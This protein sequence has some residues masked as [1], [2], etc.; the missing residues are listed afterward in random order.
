MKSNLSFGT[1]QLTR[2]SKVR[3]QDVQEGT[4]K[5]SKDWGTW[6]PKSSSD[7]RLNPIG[8]RKGWMLIQ[9]EGYCRTRCYCWVGNQ[10]L[11]EA[12]GCSPSTVVELLKEMEA[13][14][15][16]HRV[17]K[18]SGRKGRLGIIL[19][20][21][22]GSGLPVATRANLTETIETMKIARAAA[23][24]RG[25]TATVSAGPGPESPPHAT[26]KPAPMPPENRWHRAT[27]KPVAEELV[28]I[29]EKKN[30][31]EEQAASGRKIFE[32]L[33]RQR[34]EPNPE[35]VEPSRHEIQPEPEPEP[36]Q[37]EC[38]IAPIQARAEEAEPE[39]EPAPPLP[40]ITESPAP[41]PAR[42]GLTASQ[43]QFLDW[44]PAGAL[45]MF[46]ARSPE[47][48]AAELAKHVKFF[49]PILAKDF[50]RLCPAVVEAPPPSTPE[51]TAELIR[52]L[53]RGPAPWVQLL[54]ESLVRDF[55]GQKDR[56]LWS[57]FQAVSQAVWRGTFP[58]EAVADAYRQATGPKAKNGGAVFN[59]VIQRDHGW[60]WGGVRP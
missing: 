6:C 54:T 1:R 39:P 2:A 11:S 35:A 27:G 30:K 51:T 8:H 42:P 33:K 23:R 17:E 32:F 12:Y 4:Q 24:A 43:R 44:L 37:K 5:A 21:R 13:D 52:L 29:V 16:I 19:L 59:T 9:I 34:P 48:Q 57:G 31:E 49:D 20:K 58:A 28:V 45:A 56:K 36:P 25:K 14:G 3:P 26:G 60:R 46:N 50:A 40:Q 47:K 15:L 55:G 38:V 53:P 10:E 7:A 22:L 41:S 18:D